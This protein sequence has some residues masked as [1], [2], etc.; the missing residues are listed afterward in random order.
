MATKPKNPA[1]L[2]RLQKPDF[3]LRS[4]SFTLRRLRFNP[5]IGN[6]GKAPKK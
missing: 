4:A 2:F 5:K 6:S 3:V 1:P